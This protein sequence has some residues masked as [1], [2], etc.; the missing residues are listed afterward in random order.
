MYREAP[1]GAMQVSAKPRPLNKTIHHHEVL[2]RILAGPVGDSIDYAELIKTGVCLGMTGMGRIELAGTR[3]ED[4]KQEDAVLIL[5][6][7]TEFSVQRPIGA[8]R[9]L[10]I[11]NEDDLIKNSV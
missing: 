4:L 10:V 11:Y 1:V 5:S 7:P 2:V 3:I 8:I 9:T 6:K